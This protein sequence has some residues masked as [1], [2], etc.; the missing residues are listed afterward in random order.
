MATIDSEM[1]NFNPAMATIDSENNPN[2][3]EP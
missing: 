3:M 2:E 1:K